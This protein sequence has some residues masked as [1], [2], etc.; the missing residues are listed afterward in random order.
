M[1]DLAADPGELRAQGFKALVD[2]LGWANAVR[3]LRL[4]EPGLGNYTAERDALL[5][6]WDG[7]TLVRE[8]HTLAFGHDDKK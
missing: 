8:A 6:D 7:A 4:F 2:A 3:F 5:P 1:D